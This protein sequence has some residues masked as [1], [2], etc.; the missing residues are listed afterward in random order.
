ME[1]GWQEPES[2]VLVVAGDAGVYVMVVN[3]VDC[4]TVNLMKNVVKDPILRFNLKISMSYWCSK[5]H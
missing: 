2:A 4:L 5:A 3:I 1:T